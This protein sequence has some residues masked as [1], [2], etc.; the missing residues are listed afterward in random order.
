MTA[1]AALDFAPALP[2]QPLASGEIHLWFFPQWENVPSTAESAGVRGLLAAYL[3]RP[4]E[5]VRIERGEHG[6]PRVAGVKLEFNLAHT[7]TALLLGVSRAIALGVDLESTQRKTRPAIELAQRFFS[8][9]EAAALQATPESARQLAFLRLWCAKE[10][11]VKASGD[12]IAS[13]LHRVEFALDA[14]GH[15][16]PVSGSAW[17]LHELAPGPALIGALAHRGLVSRVRTFVARN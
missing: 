13:G 5:T 4:V 11:T 10:A 7:G 3:D 1:P 12:G 16:A 8:R 2:P 15:V 17:H 9:D 14:A 6:K